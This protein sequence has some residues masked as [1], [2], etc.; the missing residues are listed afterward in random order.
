M[1]SVVQH[2]LLLVACFI[3]L[4]SVHGSSEPCFVGFV[5]VSRLSQ[6]AGLTDVAMTSTSRFFGGNA[7]TLFGCH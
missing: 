7:S 3:V 5:S 4:R 6:R 1:F 2:A